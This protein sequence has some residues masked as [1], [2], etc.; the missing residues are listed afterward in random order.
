MES[1]S[2][3][4]SLWVG[5]FEA[6]REYT[7]QHLWYKIKIWMN[8]EHDGGPPPSPQVVTAMKKD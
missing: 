4:I 5:E 3:R 7:P 2:G 1:K 8:K 6:L